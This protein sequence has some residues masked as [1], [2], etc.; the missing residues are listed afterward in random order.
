MINEHKNLNFFNVIGSNIHDFAPESIDIA[1]SNNYIKKYADVICTEDIN[2]YLIMIPA[3][4]ISLWA[5]IEGEIRPAGRNHYAV[6]TPNALKKFIFEK[7]GKIESNVV[8]L[9]INNLELRK[10]SG[11]NNF[12]SGYK[13]NSIFFIYEKDCIKQNNIIS[14]NLDDVQQLNPT[15][16]GKILFN[17]PS[18]FTISDYYKKLF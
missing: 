6:W 8:E 16:S 1:V 12:V 5:K 11:R 7:G 9:N 3:D 15:V 13:I 14:F 4:Q 18:Y 10:E 2:N 17:K